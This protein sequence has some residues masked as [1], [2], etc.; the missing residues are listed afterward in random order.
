MHVHNRIT[1]AVAVMALIGAQKGWHSC[2]F[3]EREKRRIKDPKKFTPV[4]RAKQTGLSASSTVD[5]WRLLVGKRK[6]ILPWH[7]YGDGIRKRDWTIRTVQK[8]FSKHR[9][10]ATGLRTGKHM[11]NF[12]FATQIASTPVQAV[13]KFPA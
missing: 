3:N 7:A 12:G 4:A 8:E 10:K 6:T 9:Y 5:K 2:R 1:S 13:V 11:R